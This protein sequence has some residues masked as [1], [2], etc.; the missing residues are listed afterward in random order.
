MDILQKCF[1]TFIHYLNS[2]GWP[3]GHKKLMRDNAFWNAQLLILLNARQILIE[4]ALFKLLLEAR[5]QKIFC[6]FYFWT[7]KVIGSK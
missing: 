3:I 7:S 4:L 6:Y 2:L 1:A 5:Y